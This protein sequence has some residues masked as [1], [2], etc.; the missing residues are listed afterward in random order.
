MEGAQLADNIDIDNNTGAGTA[1]AGDT[2]HLLT[3]SVDGFI[4]INLEGTNFAS[5]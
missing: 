2:I 3:E 1:A 5:V 4:A